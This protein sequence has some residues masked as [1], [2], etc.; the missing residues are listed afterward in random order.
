[1]TAAE[2][3]Q[4]WLDRYGNDYDTDQQRHAAYADFQANLAELQHAFGT[5]RP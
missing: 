4:A 5:H 1:M 2:H 3:W